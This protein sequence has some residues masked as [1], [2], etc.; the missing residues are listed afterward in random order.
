MADA[1]LS[2]ATR[3]A[4]VASSK[5]P[6]RDRLVRTATAIAGPA[7]IVGAILVVYRGYVFHDVLMSRHLDILAY[8]LPNN[9]FLGET[10]RAGHIALWNPYTLGG[11]PF[12]A[13]PL[14][15]WMNLFAM[16]TFAALPCGQAMRFFIVVQP[17]IA[18]LGMYWFL[19]GES[20]SRIAAT[21][22]GL[23][24]A[25]TTAG[26]EFGLTLAFAGVI[27]WLP[28]MLGAESRCLQAGTWPRRLGWCIVTA[29]AWGQVVA[30]HLPVG[31][32]LGTIALVVYGVARIL[33][34]V[35]AGRRSRAG[36]LV[37]GAV[38]LVSVPAVN[39]AYLLP[40][41]AFLPRTSISLGYD[42][43]QGLAGHFSPAWPLKLIVP[44]G[45][46]VGAVAV[47]LAF[48]AWGS[49]RLRPLA[50]A[51]TAFGALGYLLTVR[52]FDD[53][54]GRL[55]GARAGSFL[56][57][58]GGRCL[59]AVI[60]SV[61]ALAGCGMQAFMEAD[62]NRR[63]ALL[64]VPGVAVLLIL[65]LSAGV[66]L[67]HL[68]LPAIAGAIGAVLLFAADRRPAIAIAVPLLVAVELC[69]SALS[70]QAS[71]TPAGVGIRYPGLLFRQQPLE[72]DLPAFFRAGPLVTALGAPNSGR[73]MGF[74]P[75]LATNRGYLAE[76]GP[77]SWGL[78]ANQRGSVFD[79]EDVQGYLPV[80]LLRYWTFVR[81]VSSQRL[82]YNVDVFPDPS[83]LVLDLLQVNGLV[84]PTV[85]PPPLPLPARPVVQDGGWK[86]ER[87]ERPFPRV[88]VVPTWRVVST[89]DQALQAVTAHGFDPSST[90]VL[91]RSP[92]LGPPAQPASQAGSATY[93]PLGLQSAKIS[94]TT[95]SPAIVLVRTPYDQNWHASVDGEPA[96]VLAADYVVQGIPVPAGDH[97][98][99]LSYI[100]PSIGYGLAGTAAS[101]G[102]LLAAAIAL[103]LRTRRGRS[104][105][106][107]PDDRSGTMDA[108]RIGPST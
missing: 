64:L 60:V 46:Y 56:A 13:D 28:V 11:T 86:L 105:H 103:G 21:V 66:D 16:L 65:P 22:G 3:E 96:Q 104:S 67:S 93:E 53:S 98:I 30:S 32:M 95:P 69:A 57:H 2:T 92:G 38:I 12:A 88:S 14:S 71:P 84:V 37:L 19:R 63:R 90:V 91:E 62:S 26:S 75:A 100:D 35:R 5:E 58:N 68:L 25:L 42:K 72:V 40:R 101:I 9:C 87:L 55:I 106:P 49:K 52:S 15:G 27:A 10:L 6:G 18:G 78:L 94:V 44:P 24:P 97:T 77:G 45:A 50:A 17:L 82:D 23:V 73:F 41:L 54:F 34:E 36:V 99:V 108:D 89:E 4:P 39:L 31:I 61:A 70:G 83:P 47:V 33:I 74:D 85:N 76:Q 79:L 1:V 7:L 81:A 51:L 29:L 102:A 8:Y 107:S 20:L 80:Q 43:L 48:A 59:F